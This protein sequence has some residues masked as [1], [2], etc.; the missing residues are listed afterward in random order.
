[1]NASAIL[2]SFGSAAPGESYPE[3]ISDVSFYITGLL[4]L[5][6]AQQVNI[7]P[8]SLQMANADEVR[9]GVV[10][11]NTDAEAD[12]GVED[13][14]ASNPR[15]VARYVAAWW[16]A[17]SSSTIFGKLPIANQTQAQLASNATTVM[18]P[19]RTRQAVTHWWANVLTT[20]TLLSR[21]P[22]AS[23]SQAEGGTHTES[24][25][26]PLRTAEAIAALSP[27]ADVQTFNAS[28]TWTKPT[29][30]KSVHIAIWGGGS[31][32][33]NSGSPTGTN[34]AASIVALPASLLPATVTVTIG[35]AGNTGG[36]S[37][38]GSVFATGGLPS[39]GFVSFAA[40][41]IFEGVSA[42][43]ASLGN[44]VSALAGR[45]IDTPFTGGGA[46]G[47]GVGTSGRA[48]ITTFF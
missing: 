33:V 22:F 38:F 45:N 13:R 36:N 5:S 41:S 44:G 15:G 1:M 48:I 3:K 2:V 19:Q 8:T 31:T 4:A 21:I 32:N 24:V 25:M 35:A 6:A 16:N 26:N 39:G 10:R 7:T 29:G 17:L 12:A 20:V 40:A 27:S 11:Y 30:A 23:K 28:G 37:F 18:T 42:V 9:H 34:G 46:Y 47:P 14:A 43:M